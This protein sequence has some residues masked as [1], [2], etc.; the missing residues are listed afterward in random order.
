MK[1]I[2]ARDDVRMEQ[3]K[4]GKEVDLFTFYF[5]FSIPSQFLNDF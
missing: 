2:C 4:K 5:I 3:W 1:Y